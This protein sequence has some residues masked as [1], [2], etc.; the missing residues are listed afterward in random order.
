MVVHNQMSVHKKTAAQRT[1]IALLLVLG[2]SV[3]GCRTVAAPPR[4]DSQTATTL[5]V[6]NSAGHEQSRS[7]ATIAAGDERKN[8]LQHHLRNMAQREGPPLSANNDAKL[9]IDGP[10][11]YDAIFAAIATA[12]HSIDVEIYIFDDDEIGRALADLLKT[13]Q[14]SGV[15]V[16][17]I[18][19]SVGCIKT[20]RQFFD[21]MRDAG[22]DIVEFNPVNPLAGKFLHLNNRDHRKIIIIDNRVAF[23][24]GINISSVYAHGSS[25]MSKRSRVSS[26][27][28][29]TGDHEQAMSEGWRDTQIQ[30]KGPAV[31]IIRDLF[32]STWRKAGADELIGVDETDA[33]AVASQ[34]D[35]YIRVIGSSP[36]DKINYIYADLLSAIENSQHSI[37]ITMSYFSPN[38]AMIE[39]L[40]KAAQRGVKVELVLPGFSDW[41][42]VLEAGRSHYAALLDANVVIFERKDV[43]LHAKTAV[44]DGV[45]STIGSS[46]MDMRSFL[47]NKEVNVVVLGNDFGED[48]EK[49]FADDSNNA[50]KIDKEK[51][52]ERSLLLRVK[53]GIARLFSY[54]L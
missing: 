24:G 13:K 44:I 15:Q 32:N 42:P 40:V 17:L 28:N 2:L 16:R 25:F 35:K 12:Q 27:D 4:N 54:W 10:Q 43:F 3:D 30:I 53:Q 36:D 37:H 31:K 19:D 8:S 11:T 1:T 51:W 26:K 46:N 6:V 34:G 50:E 5:D 23:T 22:I 29:Q 52:R 21:E 18:Y 9:L 49:M 33:Q 38:P 39:A 7:I 14:R 47:H 20:P 41:W 45:W 48:M